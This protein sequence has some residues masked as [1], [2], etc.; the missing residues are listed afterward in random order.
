[1][2]QVL[3]EGLIRTMHKYVGEK[4]KYFQKVKDIQNNWEYSDIKKGELVS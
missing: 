3:F 2:I 1:M 4:K